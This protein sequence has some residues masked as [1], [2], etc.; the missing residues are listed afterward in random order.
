MNLPRLR[1]TLLLAGLAA[2]LG[3]L[4][5]IARFSSQFNFLPEH[6]PAK[7]ILYPTPPDTE[8]HPA[9]P[10]W[11]VFRRELVLAGPS[12]NTTLEL[13]SFKNFA[14]EFNGVDLTHLS[15]KEANWKRATQ[16]DLTPHARPG[17][18]I[19]SV[20]VTNRTGPPALWAVLRAGEVTLT[21]DE[22]WETSL[23]GAVWQPAAFAS[24]TRSLQ[25]GHPLLGGETALESFRK[26]RW[27]WLI[28]LVVAALLLTL[29]RPML[30]RVGLLARLTTPPRGLWLSLGFVGIVWLA[31]LANNL[32]RLPSLFGF[33]TDGHTE[34]IR[35]VQEHSRLPLANEGWQ[36]YQPP[37]YYLL[38]AGLLETTALK[39]EGD[40]ATLVLRA[41]SGVIGFAHLVFLFLCLRQLFPGQTAEQTIG[42]LFAASLPALLCVSHFITNEG[43]AAMLSTATL[44]FTLRTMQT[45]K[46][47]R[48]LWGAAGGCLGLALLAKFSAIV[49][50][51]FVFALLGWHALKLKNEALLEK[52]RG[53]LLALAACALACGWHYARVWARFG[54]PLIGNWSPASGFAWWQETGF[55]TAKYFMPAGQALM[56]PLF[57]GFNSLGDGIY[58]TLWTDGLISGGARM[59]FRPPWNYSPMIAGVWLALLPTMLV[60]AGGVTLA[61]RW[62]RHAT[63]ESLLWPGLLIA[64][65]LAVAVMTLRVPSYAQAKAVYTLGALLPLCICLLAGLEMTR[66]AGRFV[67]RGCLVLLTLWMM[68]SFA[69]FWV[70]PNAAATHEALAANHLDL[71]RAAEALMAAERALVSTPQSVNAAGLRIA[72]LRALGRMEEAHAY[73]EQARNRP[74]ASMTARLEP[75]LQAA[76]Q[77][78][79]ATAAALAG[80]VA[81]QFPDDPQATHNAAYWSLE[82]GQVDTAIELCRRALRIRFA[83]P[84]LHFLLAKG[85]ATQ[86]RDAESL[87]HLRLAVHF[88]PE[89]AMAL[90]DLAWALATH[91]A[92]EFRNGG[93]AVTHAERA[94]ELTRYQQPQLIGTLA[95]A[96]AEAGRFADAT[97]T[98]TNAIQAAESIGSSSLVEKNN[99]LLQLY[100]EGKP[101]HEAR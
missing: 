19:L 64:Y 39:M 85:L 27:L 15:P 1:L 77:G 12:S 4:W 28:G 75:A 54:N 69:S 53:P 50:V 13:R 82:A 49:L 16:L 26:V 34:Y 59:T 74:D 62:V 86:V 44:Y 72:A 37:L 5:G 9:V 97:R 65:G 57:S 92:A 22:T 91:P 30:G 18:N 43:L 31:L 11:T 95:A 98:A 78:N 80:E 6:S 36:M 90:N 42:L 2:A 24:R 29:G 46:P 17:T 20:I 41:L 76:A 38:G 73:A 89:W 14:V 63:M 68:N 84:A 88:K 45:E 67:H 58:S 79:H 101:Y 51:P 23:V 56:S 32:P 93:E 3:A 55:T 7:W 70:R 96:Y 48:W 52:W 99:A 33:D 94:C 87:R 81:A 8:M 10:I 47:A 83:N 25:A 40:S 66:R 100:R 21:T 35:F 71:G 61:A 60:A